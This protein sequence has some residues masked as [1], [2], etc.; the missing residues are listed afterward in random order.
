MFN[1]VSPVDR[2]EVLSFDANSSHSWIERSYETLVPIEEGIVAMFL[3]FY[4]Y[5]AMRSRT[6]A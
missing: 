2:D 5:P 6:P 4:T 3:Y 1:H